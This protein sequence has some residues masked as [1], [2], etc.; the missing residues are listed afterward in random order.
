MLTVILYI[1]DTHYDKKEAVLVFSNLGI[2][3]SVTVILAYLMHHF[4]W[5][6]K[7]TK[8]ITSFVPTFFYDV[9]K[10]LKSCHFFTNN[11]RVRSKG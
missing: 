5:T 9:I 4:K 8:L 7:V 3:R 11:Q 2:S 6:L 10:E 1:T